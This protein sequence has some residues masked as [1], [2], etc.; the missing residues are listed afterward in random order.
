MHA[1]ATD[2]TRGIFILIF[3]CIVIGGSRALFALR[4]G[5]VG[6][7]GHF[8]SFSREALL[9]CNNVAVDGHRRRAARH[10]YPL[11]VDA[12][13]LGKLSVGAPCFQ[14]VFVPLMALVALPMGAAPLARWKSTSFAELA[15]RL[16]VPT[17]L[18]A[19]AAVA[20]PQAAR[21]RA[22]GASA[23]AWHWACCWRPGS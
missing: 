10:P 13:G 15:R 5:A 9:L 14:A 1:F 6:G 8:D 11:A 12:L 21:R 16:R 4:V 17:L 19:V 7:R 2:P 20:L 22:Q 3:L 23:S 18:S